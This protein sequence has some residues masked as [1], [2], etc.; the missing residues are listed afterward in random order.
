MDFL[1]GPTCFF[2]INRPPACFFPIN[3]PQRTAFHRFCDAR[4]A[5]RWASRWNRH[6]ARSTRSVAPSCCSFECIGHG[7]HGVHIRKVKRIIYTV[8]TARIFFPGKSTLAEFFIFSFCSSTHFWRRF[9]G[10]KSRI[11][12]V[13]K[14]VP[15]NSGFPS[16]KPLLFLI[17]SF[18]IEKISFFAKV[19]GTHR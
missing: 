7:V 12:S 5:R 18:T 4:D 9:F 19:F 14:K 2:P 10:G 8:N 11:W 13:E 3:R 17:N 1:F 16:E 15:I 6:M